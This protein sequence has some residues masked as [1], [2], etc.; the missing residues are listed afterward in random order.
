[1]KLIN[2]VLLYTSDNVLTREIVL[3]RGILR[4]K[5]SQAFQKLYMFPKWRSVK[6]LIRSKVIYEI[7]I[8]HDNGRQF[9]KL[10]KLIETCMIEYHRRPKLR[11][12]NAN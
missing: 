12:R 6:P 5:K 4:V 8:V 1:M 7:Q 9:N 11:S 10:A 2:F 3:V